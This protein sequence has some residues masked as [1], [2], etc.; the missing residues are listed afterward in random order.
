[1]P[2]LMV[3][4]DGCGTFLDKYGR[5][6]SCG[7][8]PDMQST[9]FREVDTATLIQELRVAGKSFLGQFRV[10]IELDGSG[11]PDDEHDGE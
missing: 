11:K 7:F 5:C 8:S 1:M 3:H 2:L 6:P 9:A 10:P 4:H